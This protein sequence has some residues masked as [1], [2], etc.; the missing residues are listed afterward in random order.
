MLTKIDICTMALLKLGE[1]PIQSLLDDTPAAQLSRTLFDPV[2]ETLLVMH[3][4]RFASKKIDLQKDSEGNFLIPADVLRVIK[5]PGQ[6]IGN[7][8]FAKQDE[9]SIVAIVRTPVENFPTYFS[10]LAATKL[11]MEFCVPL[12]GEQTVFKMLVALYETDLQTAKFLDSTT[13]NNNDIQDF[14]LISS[15]F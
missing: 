4:W 9:V 5:S 12:I 14:S 6:I 7:K 8:I 11:A 10:S 2:I 15:R 1:K 13:S 3:P